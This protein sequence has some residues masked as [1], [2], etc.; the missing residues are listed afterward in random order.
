MKT[1]ME[2]RME[3]RRLY[4]VIS[5]AKA[6]KEAALQKLKALGVYTPDYLL[7]IQK[8]NDE[9]IRDV[10]KSVSTEFKDIVKETISGKREA[11]N[12]MLVDAPTADQMNLLNSLQFQGN[13]LTLDE[14]KAISTQL[15][16]N[17]RAV[18]AFQMIAE[19]AG[20]RVH[21]PVECDYQQLT[22]ALNRA[23]TYLN[24][25]VHEL[26]TFTD[27]KN[28][29]FFFRMF[30][31]TWDGGESIPDGQYTPNALM[32]DSNEQTT[33]KVEPITEPEETVDIPPEGEQDDLEKDPAHK[34]IG[35]VV[36]Q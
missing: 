12:K 25:R 19:K 13:T 24:A 30:F 15:I 14:A 22:E 31:D 29:S 4:R 32:L 9:E 5:T 8:K 33:P 28:T 26:A 17:Y 3:G 35:R 23:E 16:G 11:V 18:H 2:I 36:I 10:V 34:T 1:F 21:L 27:A 20:I 7:T 6:E